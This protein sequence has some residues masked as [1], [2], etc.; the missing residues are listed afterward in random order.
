MTLL[1]FVRLRRG[2]SVKLIEALVRLFRSFTSST[3]DD[4]ARFVDQAV[5][6]ALGARRTMA[7]L[8]SVWIADQ[9]SAHAGTIL[10]PT[11][12]ADDVLARPGVTPEQVYAR[13][14]ITVRSHLSKG[15]PIAQAVSAGAAR[16][17][18][19]AEGDMQRAHSEAAR[20]AIEA[21][22][23]AAQPVGWRRVLNGDKNCPMCVVAASQLYGSDTANPLHLRCDCSVE[24]A[25]ERPSRGEAATAQL[26]EAIEALT[27]RQGGMTDSE[28]GVV[29]RLMTPNHGEL[30]SM[31][32]RPGDHFTGPGDIPS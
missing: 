26:H 22:P 16:L 14:F 28:I 30:G 4:V 6:L 21:L 12:V 31:L 1:D 9:A 15:Q 19:V 11:A 13:P 25:Y 7:D 2:L 32:V 8:T 18:E 10:A 3:D 17:E 24:L 5:P 23:P 27:G 29:L 20:S